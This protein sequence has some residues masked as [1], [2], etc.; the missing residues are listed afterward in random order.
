[1][2]HQHCAEELSGTVTHGMTLLSYA[3]MFFSFQTA[4]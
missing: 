3:Q 2:L 4:A 1:V